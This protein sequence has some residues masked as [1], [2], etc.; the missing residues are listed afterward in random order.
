MARWK[1]IRAMLGDGDVD[2]A[3][4]VIQAELGSRAGP[5]R[6][7]IEA[8]LR[9]EL[10]MHKVSWRRWL[11]AERKGTVSAGELEARHLS[12]I[13]KLLSLVSEIER[14]EAPQNSEAPERH[15][16]SNEGNL[17]KILFLAANPSECPTR[18]EIG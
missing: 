4:E 16:S 13:E 2:Q 7:R 17:I 6:A 9:T 10:P 14:I 18:N 12:L 5:Q 11:A 1:D 8:L 15:T 3:L